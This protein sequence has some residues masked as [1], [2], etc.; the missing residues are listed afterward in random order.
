MSGAEAVAA[1]TKNAAWSA[2]REDDL[3]QIKPGYVADFTV[4][5]LDPIKASANKLLEAKVEMTVV[6]GRTEYRRPSEK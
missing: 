1:F 3:G 6:G 4:F 2:F 5:D